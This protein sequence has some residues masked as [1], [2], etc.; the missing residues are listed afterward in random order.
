MTEV[1]IRLVELTRVFEGRAA[2]DAVDLEVYDGEFFSLIGPS[3]CG[4]TTTLRMIAGLE[5]ATSG[6]V[7]LGDRDVTLAPAYK[8]P[9]NTVFQQYG[10]FPHLNVFENVAFGLRERHDPKASIT[11]AVERMLG[12][13]GLAGRDRSR[14]RQL[15][16]GEQQRVALARALV[17]GPKVLLLDEPLGALDLKLRRQMQTLLKD[18]QR[19]LGITFVYVT[20]DQEEAF[21]MSDRVAVMNRGKLEQVGA[22]YDVYH[23]PSTFFV[24]DFVGASN[25]LEGSVRAVDADGLYTIELARSDAVFKAGGVP[26]LVAGDRIAALARPEAG[27]IDENPAECLRT[28]GNI[29]DVAYSGPQI[30]Y[31]VDSNGFGDL[32]VLTKTDTRSRLLGVGRHIHLSWDLADVWILPLGDPPPPTTEPTVVKRKRRTRS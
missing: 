25:C 3:G 27:C 6:R 15:S 30:S 14:P 8:R 12:L 2:V 21:G 16:G 5:T 1:A 17:L 23:R 13:V 26:G 28:D 31:T 9:I 7:L 11:P 20:H 32:T 29:K 18:L 19:E 10:L 4:K 24:A 22:P